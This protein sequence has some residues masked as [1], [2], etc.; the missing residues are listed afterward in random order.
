MFGGNLWLIGHHLHL[1]LLEP[2]TI[3]TR[4]RSL[5]ALTRTSCFIKHHKRYVKRRKKGRIVDFGGCSRGEAWILKMRGK[6]GNEIIHQLTYL[7]D[8]ASNSKWNGIRPTK[9]LDRVYH[10]YFCRSQALQ[11]L[12]LVCISCSYATTW[13]MAY[14]WCN[15]VSHWWHIFTRWGKLYQETCEWK[16]CNI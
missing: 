12:L 11:I 15:V 1:E 14:Q 8:M 9:R 16:S 5:S 2:C 6:P 7:I 4:L 3:P 10:G 13:S